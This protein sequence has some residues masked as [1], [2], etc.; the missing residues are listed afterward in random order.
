MTNYELYSTGFNFDFYYLET[1]HTYSVRISNDGSTNPF[2][3]ATSNLLGNHTAGG[4]NKYNTIFRTKLTKMS[5][6]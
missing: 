2:S 5:G 3:T 1:G 4:I 6:A